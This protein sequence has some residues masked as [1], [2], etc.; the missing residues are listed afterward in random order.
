MTKAPQFLQGTRCGRPMAWWA[1]RWR[2]FWRDVFLLGTAIGIASLFTK[3]NA[4]CTIFEKA[5]AVKR[6]P[7]KYARKVPRM[8]DA[9]DSLRAGRPVSS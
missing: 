2:F 1:R 5:S 6:D 9:V 4:G 8:G 7:G 3:M